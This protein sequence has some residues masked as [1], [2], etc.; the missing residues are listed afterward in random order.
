MSLQFSTQFTAVATAVLAAF[1][2]ITAV[3]AALAF[4]KQ[5]QEITLLQVQLR[6]QKEFGEHQARVLELQAKDLVQ[7]LEERRL[8]REQRYREQ[9]THIFIWEDRSYS[10]MVIA[11]AKNASAQPIYDMEISWSARFT[12]YRTHTFDQ[13][14]LPD[15]ERISNSGQDAGVPD[16]VDP[17]TL[18]AA[19]WFRDTAGTSWLARPNGIVE[20]VP[21]GK[22]PPHEL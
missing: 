21:P 3:V 7:S 22:E 4:W 9:A 17:A 8:S 20:E 6:D 16:N 10:G 2:I 14:L 15:D 18:N 1:A 5:S 19:L 13:P 11:H 12:S